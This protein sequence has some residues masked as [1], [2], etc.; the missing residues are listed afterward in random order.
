MRQYWKKKSDVTEAIQKVAAAYDCK[1][2]EGVLSHQMKQFVIDG[3]K[4]VSS[5]SNPDTRVDDAE[6]EENEVYSVNIVT[7]TGEGKPILL[8]GKQTTIYKRAVDKSYNL[9]M[10]ASRVIFREI[11]QKVPIMPF[12]ARD[13]EEKRARVGL[14]ECVKHELLQPY[15]VLHEK[16]GDL[17]AHIKFTVLLMPNGPDRITSHAIQELTPAKT[18]DNE[19]EIK[20]WLAL[21]VK[22]KKKKKAEKMSLE[23]KLVGEMLLNGML[24][25][26]NLWKEK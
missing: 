5:V 13:L 11:S 4:V 9:K 12:T 16:P 22:T 19:P 3:N 1:I 6:F 15:P 2:V 24:Q 18:I 14:V 10:K 23:Y 17:V 21:P 20:T 26:L 7:S 8:D 25:S